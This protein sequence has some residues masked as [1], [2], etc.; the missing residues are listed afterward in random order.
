MVTQSAVTQ[1][2]DCHEASQKGAGVLICPVEL[3]RGKEDGFLSEALPFVEDAGLV[4]DMSQVTSLDAG[5]IGVILILRQVAER[6]GN[7]LVLTNPSPRVR[8]ILRLVGLDAILVC[9]EAHA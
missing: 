6:E 2:A 1:S 5:G 3:V 9:N 7:L 4:V 8:Q